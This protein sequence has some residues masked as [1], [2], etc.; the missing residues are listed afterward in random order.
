MTRT[1]RLLAVALLSFQPAS[2]E[3]IE[4]SASGFTVKTVVTVAESPARI[5]L[6]EYDRPSGLIRSM[7]AFDDSAREDAQNARLDLELALNRLGVEREVVLLQAPSED[8]LRQTHR[9]YFENLHQL[10]T[11]AENSTA[12]MVVR[13]TND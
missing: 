9:R 12:A 6:I 7:R 13:E 1:G 5:F 8:A 3:V 4:R 2:A 10:I 11:R